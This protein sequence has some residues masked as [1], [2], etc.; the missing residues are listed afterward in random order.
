MELIVL[1]T[2]NFGD[3][4]VCLCTWPNRNQLICFVYELKHYVGSILCCK[5]LYSC[6]EFYDS[7]CKS[8]LLCY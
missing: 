5:L 6:T 2:N 7:S 8:G 3:S 4:A 1:L